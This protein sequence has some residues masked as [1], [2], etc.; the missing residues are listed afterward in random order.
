MSMHFTVK[1]AIH[2]MTKISHF[3]FLILSLF[4]IFLFSYFP[5]LPLKLLCNGTLNGVH[6][7]R[8]DSGRIIFNGSGIHHPETSQQTTKLRMGNCNVVLAI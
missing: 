7:L 4:F 6:F 3:N 5:C 8:R 2:K 1:M